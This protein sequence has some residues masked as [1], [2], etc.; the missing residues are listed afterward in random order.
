M[1]KA[2][3]QKDNLGCSIACFAFIT[4][5]QHEEIANDLGKEKDLKKSKSRF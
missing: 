4:N 2:I 3:V 5:K 1:K